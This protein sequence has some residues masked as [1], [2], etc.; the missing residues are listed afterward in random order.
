MTGRAVAAS[1]VGT[2]AAVAG[3]GFA[4]DTTAPI[5]LA[6]A[7][8]LPSS[9]PGMIGF[10]VAYGLLALVPGANPSSSSGSA[11]CSP[12]GECVSST[13]GGLAPWFAVT[14]DVVGVLAMA[15]AA[16]LNVLVLRSLLRAR[17]S[18]RERPPSRPG[19]PP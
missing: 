8:A 10:Y 11:S 13:T 18:G 16:L 12:S 4:T 1:Y 19:T 7:L 17:A 14:T 9:V 5:L 6:A 3:W 2:V 15:G